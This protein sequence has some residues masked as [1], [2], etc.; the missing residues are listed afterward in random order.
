[1]FRQAKHESSNSQSRLPI[2]DEQVYD[3]PPFPPVKKPRRE[4]AT[5]IRALEPAACRDD[6]QDWRFVID[7]FNDRIMPLYG[8]QT[9]ALNK[10]A[11]KEGEIDRSCRVVYDRQTGERVGVIVYKDILDKTSA[12]RFGA[13]FELKTL[14]IVNPNR[15]GGKGIGKEML[16]YVESKAFVM[17]A[18]S[19]C[20]TV[21]DTAKDSLNFFSKH[22]YDVVRRLHDRYVEGVTENVMYKVYPRRDSS[23]PKALDTSVSGGTNVSLRFPSQGNRIRQGLTQTFSVSLKEPYLRYIAQG[24]K[25]VEGRIN[26]GLFSKPCIGDL[27]VFYNRSNRVK[28]VIHSI[29]TY[30]TFNDMLTA[31]GV[32]TCLP[33]HT[34]VESGVA[35]YHS[36]PGYE[37]RARDYGVVALHLSV[38]DE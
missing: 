26:A 2:N 27:I 30:S 38:V 16:E 25:T 11:G 5:R 7:A 13:T 18:A 22:G 19:V 21:S 14:F 10:I 8:D 33:D 3:V 9:R 15:H 24:K 28:C 29:Y 35:L 34:N 6:N 32:K 31:E 23:M 20:V 37:Q 17:G 36:F 4:L 1:M 12:P